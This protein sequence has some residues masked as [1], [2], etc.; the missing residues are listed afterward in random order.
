MVYG[1]LDNDRVSL[2]LDLYARY[3][4][5]MNIIIFQDTLGKYTNNLTTLHPFTPDCRYVREGQVTYLALLSC[6]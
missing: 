6:T 5:V 1:A 3:T 2:I 4:V